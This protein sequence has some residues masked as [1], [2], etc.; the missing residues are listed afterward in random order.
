MNKLLRFEIKQNLRRP[1]R[2]YVKSQDQ[3]IIYGYFHTDS[4]ESFDGWEQLSPEQQ[5]ELQ[6]FIQ[7]IQAI[8][9]C[10][11]K[12]SSNKM[13]DFRF[14]LPINFVETLYEISKLFAEED[15]KINLFESALTG[16]IQQLKIGTAK[17]LDEKKNKALTLLDKIGLAEYKKLDMSSQIQAVF[18]E[19]LAIRDR[20]KKLQD[21]AITLFEKNKSY[22]P[23][24]L[25]GMAK[26]ETLPS[27][28]LVACAIEILMKEKPQIIEVT[29]SDNDVFMLWAKQLLDQGHDVSTV[30]DKARSLNKEELINKIKNYI[31]PGTEN[32]S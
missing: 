2:I 11:G 6:F 7:N 26:G 19:L 24:A 32:K 20:S 21:Q 17:L 18:A 13:I 4:P 15:I 9:T 8:N 28:W 23:N 12:E 10:L 1:T 3:K 25:A 27:K 22:S 5:I 30:L 16:M 31:S 14:R 29:L